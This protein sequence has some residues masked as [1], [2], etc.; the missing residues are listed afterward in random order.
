[1]CPLEL[2][3]SRWRRDY[4]SST[5]LSNIANAA[6]GTIGGTAPS[7]LDASSRIPDSED[8]RV[9]ELTAIA[10]DLV[11]HLTD[12]SQIYD[13]VRG[14]L[15]SSAKTLKAQKSMAQLSFSD[16]DIVVRNPLRIRSRGRPKIGCKRFKS[17]AEKLQRHGKKTSKRTK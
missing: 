12:D 8:Q 17:T 7:N 1:M 9:S 2:F 6:F 15:L 5:Q 3:N 10:K 14:S 11:L 4:I 16:D 13:M